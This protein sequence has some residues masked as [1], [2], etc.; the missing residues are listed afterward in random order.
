MPVA[1]LAGTITAATETDVTLALDKPVGE[2]ITVAL[3]EIEKA[4][5]TFE[6][7]PAPKPGGPKA[8]AG[9]PKAKPGDPRAKTKSPAAATSKSQSQPTEKK[10]QP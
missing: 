10:V 2:A 8:K 6:W 5:T 4:R 1:R 9:G 3:D 7:G